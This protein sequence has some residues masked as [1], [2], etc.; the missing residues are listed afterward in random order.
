MV[1]TFF[2]DFKI[3]LCRAYYILLVKII[4]LNLQKKKDNHGP[5]LHFPL[6]RD[7]NAPK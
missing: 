7:L 6:S 3:K 1:C 4:G 2:Y 5:S